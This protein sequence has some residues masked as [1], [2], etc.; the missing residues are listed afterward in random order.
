MPKNKNAYFRYRVIDQC[1]NNQFKHFD[2]QKLSEVLT[3]KCERYVSVD[4]VSRD[5]AALKA[6]FDAPIDWNAFDKHYYYSKNFSLT[7]LVLDDE[8]EI[9][10][11]ASLAVLDILKDTKLAKSYKNLIQ[12]I[13]T[14]AN[15][16]ES[17]EANRVIEFE[18][19]DVKNGLDWF[20]VLYDAILEMQ[21]LKITYVVY[22]KEAKEH[23]VSPYM[24]KEYRNRFYL[25][26]RNHASKTDELIYCYGMDRI[27]GIKKSKEAFIT[28]KGFNSKTYFKHSFG[29]TRK[30]NEEPLELVLKFNKFNA[31]YILSKPLHHSQKVIEQTDDY[32]IVSIKVYESHELNMA[33][34]SNGSGVEVIEPKSYID[35]IKGEAAQMLKTYK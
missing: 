19:N 7:G 16:H 34:L 1:L 4:C 23:I 25:V 27:K 20:D 33:I 26:A 30:L 18:K 21:P 8:E 12:R 24:I 35:Y 32:V 28:T 10:L 6:E 14:E 15:T 3:K 2:R 11:K 9:S 17:N 5:I 13:I 29:I 31:H 22:G